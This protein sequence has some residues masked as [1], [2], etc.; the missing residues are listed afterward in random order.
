MEAESQ[1][2]VARGWVRGKG[3]LFNGHGIS[4]WGDWKILELNKG[5]GCTTFWMY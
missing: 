4:Y 2:V 5:D 3:E 1:L